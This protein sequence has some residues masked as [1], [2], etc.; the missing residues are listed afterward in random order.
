MNGNKAIGYLAE[1]FPK[2]FFVLGYQ[3]RP[4]KI[5]LFEDLRP[6]VSLTEDDLKAALRRYTAADGYLVAC[7]EG[8]IRIDLNGDAAGTTITAC[9]CL[10]RKYHA[11]TAAMTISSTTPKRPFRNSFL[12]CGIE[13]TLACFKI[14]RIES[15]GEPV[16]G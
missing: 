8:A 15:L 2:C 11:P 6:L 12:L 1:L 4:L 7:N 9:F 3:R 13:Q 14:E 5:G 16:I 10:A